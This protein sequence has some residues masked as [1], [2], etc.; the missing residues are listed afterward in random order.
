MHKIALNPS[1]YS[2]AFTADLFEFGIA[3]VPSTKREV[4]AWLSRQKGSSQQQTNAAHKLGAKIEDCC[5]DNRCQSPSC[6]ACAFAGRKLFVEMAAGFLTSQ[7]TPIY[8]F[9]IIPHDG[10]IQPGG[11]NAADHVRSIRRNKDRLAKAGLP[12]FLGAWDWSLN[13]H[14]QGRYSPH[15]QAH[16]YGF[17]PSNDPEP[18]R[19]ELRKLFL[20][21]DACPRPIAIKKW[22][23]E[24][25]ALRYAMKGNFYRRIGADEGTRFDGNGGIR[26]CRETDKQPLK[27]V[28]KLELLL[29]L[30][31]IGFQGR[32]FLRKIQFSN[33]SGRGPIFVLR[34]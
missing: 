16:I 14:V 25:T 4:A 33:L 21:T 28:E 8:R 23:G 7:Q 31:E 17:A 13:E 20:A 22:D 18:L 10:T 5:P 24:T 15:W 3:S 32:F 11:L 12:C 2:D 9:S 1:R 34:P 27:K 26:E 19:K 6:P 30:D 29:F